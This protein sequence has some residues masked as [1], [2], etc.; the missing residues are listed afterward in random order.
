MVT[1][2]APAD[3]D[4]GAGPA[5][6]ADNYA[7]VS[8]GCVYQGCN[9]TSEC[10]TLGDYVCHDAGLGTR[11]CFPACAG[12]ADCDL[13]AGPA[14][15]ADNYTCDEGACLYAGCNDTSECAALGD[16]VC[17]DASRP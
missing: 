6:D 2:D 7:C 14:F 3:C 9:T 1:C 10:Q 15:D 17:A 4:L 5:Y 16:Y 11:H 8:G 12:P 13:G